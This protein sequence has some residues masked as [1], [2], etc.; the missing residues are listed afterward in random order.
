MTSR[1]YYTAFALALLIGCEK[2]MDPEYLKEVED[3]HADRVGRLTKEDG[4]LALAGLFWLEP[5][6]NSVG[7]DPKAAVALPKGKAPL[8]LGTLF[9]ADGEVALEIEA[10]VEATAAGKQLQG[11]V[12]LENDAKGKP[13]LVEHGRLLFYVIERSGRLGIRVKDRDSEARKSFRGIERYPIDPSFK[14]NARFEKYDPPGSIEIASVIGTM[15]K[16]P[17]PGAAVF[18]LGGKQHRLEAIGESDAEELFFV[19]AD[20]TNGKETYGAGRFLVAAAPAG[21]SVVLDFNKAYSPPC[22]FTPYATCPLPPKENKLGL[23]IEAG[24]K[25]VSH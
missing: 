25:S 18:E 12:T 9:V 24:E 6:T 22:A 20:Q 14:I 10:G 16:E 5:G 19:F 8:S 21:G 1:T 11:R 13:T 2:K 15:E 17:S 3:W 23:R 4:W 7:S